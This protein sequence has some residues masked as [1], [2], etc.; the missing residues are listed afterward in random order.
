MAFVPGSPC[1][2]ANR[3]AVY[4]NHAETLLLGGSI[5]NGLNRYEGTW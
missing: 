4:E 5:V 1:R 3:L 2:K